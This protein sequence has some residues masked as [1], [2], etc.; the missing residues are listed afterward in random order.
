MLRMKIH[1]ST[2]GLNGADDGALT[3]LDASSRLQ[4][5][6][7]AD[8]DTG[9]LLATSSLPGRNNTQLC[10]SSSAVFVEQRI[11][12]VLFAVFSLLPSLAIVIAFSTWTYTSMQVSLEAII[13]Y[14]TEGLHLCENYENRLPVKYVIL[15]VYT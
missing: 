6:M 3:C 7:V 11:R 4:S 1:R 10:S 14:P 2:A 8:D 12:L 13:Q 15:A 5:S 9:S